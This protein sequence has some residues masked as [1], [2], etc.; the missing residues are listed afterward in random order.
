MEP[1]LSNVVSSS[2]CYSCYWDLKYGNMLRACKDTCMRTTCNPF[3]MAGLNNNALFEVRWDAE[4]DE[5]VKRFSLDILVADLYGHTTSYWYFYMLRILGLELNQWKF[6]LYL[7]N[8]RKF[9]TSGMGYG[10]EAWGGVGVFPLSLGA[11]RLSYSTCTLEEQ[12][13]GARWGSGVIE[14][15]TWGRVHT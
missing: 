3:A 5:W 14:L 13:G 1:N 9:C 12:K 7:I 4:E 2:L 6:I 10:R 15:K 11:Q 8:L